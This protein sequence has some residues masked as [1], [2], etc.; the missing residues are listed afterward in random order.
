MLIGEE[1]REVGRDVRRA[2]IGQNERVVRE[3]LGKEI[4]STLKKMKG[5]K[6][7]G[8]DGIVVEILKN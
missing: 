1:I 5:G 3:V 7:T 2:S 4:M 8:M 6:A